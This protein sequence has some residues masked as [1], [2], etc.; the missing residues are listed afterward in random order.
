MT[1]ENPEFSVLRVS[2]LAELR[3]HEREIVRRIRATPNG[4]RLLLLDPQRL[5][6]DLRVEITAGSV[7]ECRAAHPEFFT[8]TG[9]EHAYDAV[10]KSR[11][12]GDINVTVSGL[13]RKRTS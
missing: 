2:S 3:G 4:G 13:F 1:Y 9:R 7:E 11:P 6:R 12:G 5:L 8:R 10:A